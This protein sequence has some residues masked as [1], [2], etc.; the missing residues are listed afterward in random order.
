MRKKLLALL[1]V[2]L[3]CVGCLPI[4]NQLFNKSME[5]T[6]NGDGMKN[7]LMMVSLVIDGKWYTLSE[8]DNPTA[9]EFFNKVSSDGLEALT[10]ADYGGFEKNTNLPWSLS[11]DLDTNMTVNPGDVVLYQ[12]KTLVL[13]YGENTADYTKIGS[14]DLVSDEMDELKK[15]LA[16]K[17]DIQVDVVVE[18]T[19]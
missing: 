14:I 7:P 1:M 9:I 12:G 11:T 17:K 18:Y 3:L 5:P 10:M 19:E 15:E 2:T 6:N 13:I 4:E 8:E 16:K